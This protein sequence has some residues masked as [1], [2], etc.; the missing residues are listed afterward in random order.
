MLLWQPVVEVWWQQEHLTAIGAD[1]VTH[2]CT[3]PELLDC[4]Q[5][6]T[7]MVTWDHAWSRGVGFETASQGGGFFSAPQGA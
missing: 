4:V 7:R 3:T 2:A 1:G 5:R 6:Q